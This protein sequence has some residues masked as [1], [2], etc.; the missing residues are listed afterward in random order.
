[1]LS[2]LVLLSTP[3]QAGYA[4]RAFYLSSVGHQFLNWELSVTLCVIFY[5]HQS[6]E[7]APL[8]DVYRDWFLIS[9]KQ[10]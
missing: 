3:Q 9:R 7:K 10:S 8:I 6:K 2:V 1:M 4:G 5:Q